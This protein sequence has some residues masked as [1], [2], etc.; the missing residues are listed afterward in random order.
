MTIPKRQKSV[1]LYAIIIIV[2]AG[3]V[4]FLIYTG[5]ISAKEVSIAF[6]ASLGTFLG[7]LFAFRL[8]EN[9]ETIKKLSGQRASLN[10]ALFV[11][12][13][14]RNAVNTFGKY[15]VPFKSE[16][17]R[18][19]NLPAH[20]PPQ[21]IDLKHNFEDLEFLLQIDQINLLMRLTVEQERFHQAFESLRIRNEF[22]VDELLPELSKHKFQGKNVTDNQ[23]LDA[24][25]ERI[26]GTAINYADGLYFHIDECTQSIPAMHAELFAVAK[27]LFPNEKF[28]SFKAEA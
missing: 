21:Y 10:R 16:I 20:K 3:T 28:I 19:I 1:Y 13:R 23:L 25:G 12:A 15:L 27:E 22:Y 4:I 8:N 26:L 24:L 17:E 14:Q 5:I 11:L 6:L 9:K 2:V 7:A 18:A